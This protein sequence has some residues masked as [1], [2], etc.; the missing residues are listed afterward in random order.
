MNQISPI[1]ERA[2]LAD[3]VHD[4]I[5]DAICAGRFPPGAVLRQEKLAED[6]NVSRQPI[7][8]ALGILRRDGLIEPAGKRG[9]RVAAVDAD[10]VRH[11]YELRAAFD[12][13]AARLAAANPTP[14]TEARLD[15]ALADGDR[16][17][18]RGETAELVDS[19]IAFHA[20]IYDLSGNPMLPDASASIWRQVRRVMHAVLERDRAPETVWNEHADIARAIKRGDSD[21]AERLARTHATNAAARL[22]AA[23]TETTP[24]S[25]NGEGS[26]DEARRDETGDVPERGLFVPAGIVQP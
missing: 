19:D 7:I 10:L 21:A 26:P 13:L 20:V 23:M 6:L 18:R 8:Q 2:S 12:G 17:L 15:A 5:V 1:S 4:R 3:E 9:Y 16:A 11:A 25:T 24:K 22:V 14:E